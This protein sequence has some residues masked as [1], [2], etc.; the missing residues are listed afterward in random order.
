MQSS[1]SHNISY[2]KNFIILLNRENQ[3]HDKIRPPIPCLG[4]AF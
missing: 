2:K 3:K 1:P 4:Q